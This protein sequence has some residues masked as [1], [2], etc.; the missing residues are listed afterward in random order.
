[1]STGGVTFAT[2]VTGQSSNPLLWIIDTAPICLGLLAGLVGIR[3]DRVSGIIANLDQHVLQRTEELRESELQ[4]NQILQ[5]TDQ[6]IYGVDMVGRCTFINESA[7]S[8]LGFM[9]EECLGRELHDLIHHSYPDG[10]PYPLVNCPMY[11]SKLTGTSSRIDDEVL[12]RKDGTPIAVEYSSHP[13]VE[14]GE[15]IGAVVTFTD[16]SERKSARIELEQA[17]KEAE[18]SNRVLNTILENMADWVWEVDGNGQYIYCS[19]QVEACL[20]FT[21]DEIVGKTPFDLMPP[22]ETEKLGPLFTEASRLKLPIHNLE[23]WNTAKDGQRR[24]LLTN[25]AP[26]IDENGNLTGY[27]GVDRDITELKQFESELRKLSRAVT[28]SPVSIVITDLSGTIEFV[29]PTF[30]KLTGY[31][32]EEAIGQNPRILNSG[33]TPVAT[34]EKLWS[35]LT[36]GE[37]WEGEFH[38][39]GK[40]G[41]QFWEHAVIS[42]LRDDSGAITHYLAVKENITEQKA[43]LR[44]L[45]EAKDKA[46]AATKAKSSFLSTMSHEIRTP[47]NGVIGMTNL[48]LDTELS[49]EQRD[50]AEIV[51]KS[52]ENLLSL[53]N[54]ILD[55]SK[56]EAGKLDVEMLAFDLRTTVEETAEL[57]AIR[58]YDN[59]L[60]LICRIDPKIPTGLIGDPGRI[61]QILTNLTGNAIKFTSQGEVV[62][63]ATLTADQG[64]YVTILFEV[65]DSGIGIPPERLGA[66][67]DPFTQVDGSTTRKYGGTG[68]G[69][70]ICR[71]L[72]ELMGGE[73]GVSSQIGTG[74]TFW[75]T[76]RL[77]KHSLQNLSGINTSGIS[78]A[79]ISG[80]RIL[81]VD[82]N[83]TSR[84]LMMTLLD[85]LGCR[86]DSASDGEA[87][88]LLLQEGIRANDPFRVVLMDREMPGINGAE[89][90][91]RI[92]SDTEL[93]STL[94]IMVTTIGQRGD[95][96][97][98]EQIGFDGYLTKPVRQSQLR[99]CIA[100]VL[101]RTAESSAKNKSPSGIITRHTVAEF[102][103]QGVRILLAED[104]IINQ[105]V[106]Q[107]I[108]NK[109]GYKAD[110]VAD[111]LEAVQALAL[112]NYDL[113]LMDI[114]MPEMDG[115]EATKAIRD[116][117]SN[118]LNHHVPIIAMTAN[119][120][121][122]DKEECLEAGMND[123]LSKPVK[124]DALS[125]VLVKWLNAGT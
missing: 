89:L 91:R 46:E 22:A 111:G 54:D 28:Q 105:K 20:G 26:I 6:G 116:Q 92:K 15:A 57:L 9:R 19:P 44:Q 2:V 14:N 109:L 65:Q 103:E 114:Q 58:A 17:H 106:A 8:I 55:F 80:T 84:T 87:G 74:S 49:S 42:S 71:Q 48:L 115:L 112:I 64:V 102:S 39:Q 53:I 121:Q 16:I 10:S 119:A 12:W 118:V 51:R 35:T 63:S 18:K 66:I 90:G 99:D 13:I 100:L 25:A 68:L 79:A 32:A 96:T 81:I 45:K 27:R 56:I 37:T 75:F 93:S 67:F 23:N 101:G 41:Q 7:L 50:Y 117:T 70:A 124:K 34:F 98:M 29:N 94:M 83:A 47:M 72:V 82:D 110:V 88:L 61:R 76:V 107:S 104:N 1:M 69:L 30:T 86:F 60:E 113:V 85:H 97:L 43:I 21:P 78:K 24:L 4:L 95:A 125:E 31:S 40:Y 108:L 123:Y 52:G 77:E 73:I 122:G 3:Q 120:M 36:S 11:C 33:L 38:N 5:T 62:I 59:G